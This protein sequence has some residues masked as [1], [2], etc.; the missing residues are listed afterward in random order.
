MFSPP[1]TDRILLRRL[2]SADA[3]PLA[4]MD[5]DPLVSANF[6][7]MVP[8]P[9]DEQRRMIEEILIPR[10]DE[11]NGLGLFLAESRDDARFLGWFIFR[12]AARFK[13]A[14]E[15]A[16]AEGDVELGYRFRSEEWGKGFATEGS[17]ALVAAAPQVEGLRRVVGIA[18]ETNLAS[19]RVLV[20][21]GLKPEREGILLH[22][23]DPHPAASYALLVE[24]AND[25]PNRPQEG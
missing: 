20:K 5:A 21:A 14:A 22:L 6:P 8:A 17:R 24:R 7:G 23:P 2:T 10:Y 19:R 15:A 12:P 13:F 3:E 16:W 25:A 4:A 18:L 1:I 11:D 9:P